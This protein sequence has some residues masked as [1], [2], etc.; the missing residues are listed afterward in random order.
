MTDVLSMYSTYTY[1]SIPAWLL[2]FFLNFISA[3]SRRS[4][5]ATFR[6]YPPESLSPPSP[7]RSVNFPPPRHFSAPIR[8]LIVQLLPVVF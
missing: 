4:H 8:A 6:L 7:I 2:P 5:F 1:I 3:L